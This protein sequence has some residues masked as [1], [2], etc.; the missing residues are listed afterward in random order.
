MSEEIRIL[1]LEDEA[2]DV[3]LISGRLGQAGLRHQLDHVRDRASFEKAFSSAYYNIIL[4]DYA[5]PG[6]SGFNA[7]QF[8]R[9]RSPIVPF[10]LLSGTLSEEQAVESLKAG[11]TDYIIKQRLDRLVPAITR[12]LDE[13]KVRRQS[14]RAAE[15]LRASE[16]RFKLAARA[17]NDVIW[18]WEVSSDEI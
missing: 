16:E 6:Y 5:V 3:E 17:T 2:L 9:A 7:L 18:E 13:A 11:A 8:V 4:S 12:A 1:F 14:L 10:I 15:A